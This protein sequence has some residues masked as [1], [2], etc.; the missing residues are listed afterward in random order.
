MFRMQFDNLRE[1]TSDSITL[2]NFILCPILA[3]IMS[4]SFLGFFWCQHKKLS[5]LIFLMFYNNS[6]IT[7]PPQSRSSPLFHE[8]MHTNPSRSSKIKYRRKFDNSH[9]LFII[10]LIHP[11]CNWHRTPQGS[12][13]SSPQNKTTNSTVSMMKPV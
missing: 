7:A 2:F 8:H 9:Y 10:H 4:Y 3:Y 5:I 12:L 13:H 1:N 11:S 6:I